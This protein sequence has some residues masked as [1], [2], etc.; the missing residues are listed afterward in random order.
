[1]P[2]KMTENSWPSIEKA[3]FKLPKVGLGE[4]SMDIGENSNS[5]KSYFIIQLITYLESV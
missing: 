3:R 5:I 2:Q 4:D 1:M